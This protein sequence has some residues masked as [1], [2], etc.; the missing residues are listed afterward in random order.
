MSAP[1]LIVEDEIKI[2][3]VLNEYCIQ[4]GYQTVVL[5][6]G[7]EAIQWLK[8]NQPR[9]VL[10][11]LMLP[12]VDGFEICK[13]IRQSS[14][15]PIIMITARVEEID[16]LL[17]LNLGADD[18][19]CKPFSP[20]EVIAR[21][22]VILRRIERTD[23]T[24]P[25][26]ALELDAS[27]FKVSFSGRAIELT[28]VEFRLFEALFTNPG[29]IISRNQLMD[30]IYSDNRIVTDRTIDSHVKKIRRK[31]EVLNLPEDPV[32]SVYGA[33]YKFE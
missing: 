23:V 25:A 21:M 18:Y 8:S 7:S 2:A 16:R 32:Y 30:T 17:G 31:L 26:S 3:D 13:S 4:A 33:G 14:D 24:Q 22:S 20:R 1:V 9:M 28:S 11:D 5:H 12:G 6:D 10:L 29:R 19:V 15:M 27:S